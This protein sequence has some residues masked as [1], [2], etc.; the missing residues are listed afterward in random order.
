M[1]HRPETNSHHIIW[2]SLANEY[3]VEMPENRIRLNTL[4]HDALHK[5]FGVLL[6]PREQLLEMRYIY[7]SVL[8]TTAKQLFSELLALKDKDFYIEWMVKNGKRERGWYS[9]EE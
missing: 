4:R 6:T 8:S 9:Q 5:L 3:N 1:K 7:E 2:K